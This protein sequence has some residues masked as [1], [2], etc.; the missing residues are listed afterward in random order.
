MQKH[1][2]YNHKEY[3]TVYAPLPIGPE[4]LLY[5]DK[6]TVDLPF[7]EDFPMLHYHD[8]YEIG[9]CEDG[10]G[11]F[12]SEGKYFSVNKGSFI[13]VPPMS[14]HYSR[15][16]HGNAPCQCR[17]VYI[18]KEIIDDILEAVGK[19]MCKEYERRIPTVISSKDHSSVAV[20]L[21][22]IIEIACNDAE[23]KAE[24]IGLR[25]SAFLLESDVFR[26][27]I[28]ETE[29]S[30]ITK[31]NKQSVYAKA[32]EYLYLHYQGAETAKELAQIFHISESQLRRKF[33]SAY[34]MPP[35][36]YRNYLRCKI[37]TKLLRNTELSIVDI[38]E[39]IGYTSTS[40]FYRMF[41]KHYGIS[42]S[43]YRKEKI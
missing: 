37:A 7:Y 40:D 26:T 9:V 12:L 35:I 43:E 16:I 15:S 22:Q 17:F 3:L 28:L 31:N 25:L 27:D 8:R 41:K 6:K 34:G 33:L 32:A 36:A 11:L 19:K 14:R 20:L 2:F 13:F 4:T 5:Y 38:S 21:S 24:S 1:A 23:N 42:P 29:V 10:E 18:K 39:K 30:D